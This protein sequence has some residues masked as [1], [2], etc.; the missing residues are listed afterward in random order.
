MTIDDPAVRYSVRDLLARIDG[1]IDS[2]TTSV[3]LKADKAD[4]DRIESRLDGHDSRIVGLE[5]WKHD[6]E[7]AATVHQQ[8]DNRWSAKKKTVVG[9]LGT[10]GLLVATVLGPWLGTHWH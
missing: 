6:K 8:R 3:A 4:L 5:T 9:A 2:L 10:L 1:K 7:V